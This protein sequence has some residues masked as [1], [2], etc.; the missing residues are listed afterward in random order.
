MVFFMYAR[1]RVTCYPSLA[2]AGFEGTPERAGPPVRLKRTALFADKSLYCSTSSG[3]IIPWRCAIIIIM[4]D[5]MRR[6]SSV[7]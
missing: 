4:T 7:V 6:N 1:A 5:C 3:G 2:V